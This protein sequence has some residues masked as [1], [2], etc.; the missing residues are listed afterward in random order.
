MEARRNANDR[1]WDC[2][3]HLSFGV[4]FGCDRGRAL[5]YRVDSERAYSWVEA[6]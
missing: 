2:L 6:A 1:R 3:Q 4:G 5:S